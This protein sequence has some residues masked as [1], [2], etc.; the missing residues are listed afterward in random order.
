MPE[1]KSKGSY[2]FYIPDEFID[3]IDSDDSISR[4]KAAREALSQ[5][6]PENINK[7]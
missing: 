5:W 3:E 2:T 6:I 4:S 1:S 7:E